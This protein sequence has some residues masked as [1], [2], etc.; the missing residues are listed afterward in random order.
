MACSFIDRLHLSRL[1]WDG[2]YW[3]S[4]AN[5]YEST[6]ILFLSED[7][8]ALLTPESVD[9]SSLVLYRMGESPFSIPT[10][11]LC[12]ACV[13]L[14][15]LNFQDGA[16]VHYILST[17]IFQLQDMSQWNS[18]SILHQGGCPCARPCNIRQISPSWAYKMWSSANLSVMSVG[19]RTANSAK[20][21]IM[22]W[23]PQTRATGCSNKTIECLAKETFELWPLTFETAFENVAQVG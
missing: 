1:R 15:V 18:K 21:I 17:Y 3:W 6:L 19:S 10:R 20:F 12:V 14:L 22:P 16:L 5:N 8:L 2:S 4:T 11:L 7:M 23:C 13:V 9:K